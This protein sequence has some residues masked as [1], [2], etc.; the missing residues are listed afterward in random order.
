MVDKSF[1]MVDKN[2]TTLAYYKIN[3]YICI[4]FTKTISAKS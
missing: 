1:A 4:Q 3:E 2:K